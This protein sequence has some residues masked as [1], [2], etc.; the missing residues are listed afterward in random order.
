MLVVSASRSDFAGGTDG[1]DGRVEGVAGA[2]FTC[3]I[4]WSVPVRARLR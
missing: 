2:C 3:P 1:A 4:P